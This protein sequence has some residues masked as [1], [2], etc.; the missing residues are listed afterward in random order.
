MVVANVSVALDESLEL[1]SAVPDF[2]V[3]VP[4]VGWQMDY[5]ISRC[6]W[7]ASSSDGFPANEIR[8]R[9]SPALDVALTVALAIF[10]PTTGFRHRRRPADVLHSVTQE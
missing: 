9:S 3:D 7:H 8:Q 2:R 10:M 6:A 4:G 1:P 5:E